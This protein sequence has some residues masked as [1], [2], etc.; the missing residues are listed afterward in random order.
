MF[1]KN[2]GMSFLGGR[3]KRTWGGSQNVFYRGH[4]PLSSDQRNQMKAIMSAC[5]SVKTL[6]STSA[7][8]VRMET[9]ACTSLKTMEYKVS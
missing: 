5:H 2:Y 4:P 9:D 8:D 7:T 1:L 6:F 3:W